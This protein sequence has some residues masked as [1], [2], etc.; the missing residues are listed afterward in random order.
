[1]SSIKITPAVWAAEEKIA[2]AYRATHD[3]HLP[4]TPF[5]L[6]VD[7][8]YEL[9]V[10]T[11]HLDRFEHWHGWKI[12]CWEERNYAPTAPICIP[13]IPVVPVAPE[14]PM[15]GSVPEPA[16]IGML[17]LGIMGAWLARRLTRRAKRR[18]DFEQLESRDLPQVGPVMISP[19]S[20]L[21][22]AGSSTAPVIVAPVPYE[23]VGS[24]PPR[25]TD[26]LPC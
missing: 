5:W 6:Y 18:I 3:D 22:G 2:E 23:P 26:V 17:G 24:F 11:G 19:L 21:S 4:P 20:P 10:D 1:M 13:S 7:E 16:S 9:A 12:T 25:S 14:P 15:A 8:H